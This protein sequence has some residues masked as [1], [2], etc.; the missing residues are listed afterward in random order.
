MR[1]SQ[2]VVVL[3]TFLRSGFAI[4]PKSQ[5]NS[6][7]WYAARKG[8]ASTDTSQTLH[9]YVTKMEEKDA[10]REDVTVI[11]VRDG[12]ETKKSTE[13][14]EHSQETDG[15]V[16]G[17]KSKKSN[18]VGDPDDDSDDDN[19]DELTEWEDVGQEISQPLQV[20]VELVEQEVDDHE[21]SS[22]TSG[23]VGIR[24][25]RRKKNRRKKTAKS[26]IP[27][28]VN[29]WMPHIYMPPT[30]ASLAFFHENAR[31]IDAAGKSRLDRRTLYSGLLL[32]FTSATTPRR[33]Y[34]SKE[35]TQQLQ[36]AVSLATQPQWRSA[37]PQASGIMLYEPEDEKGGATLSMQE[38]IAM[39]LVSGGIQSHNNIYRNSPL[40]DRLTI[41]ALP[42]LR[43]CNY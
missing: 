29:T 17:V 41:G 40:T 31:Q 4:H 7:R 9:D 3:L 10:S 38:T 18:A 13:S 19:D 26:T 43:V 35:T 15:D 42:R 24:L 2:A 11:E 8:V 1:I 36:A 12:D 32:E 21:P 37:F 34:F 27:L 16:V 23:G 30:A 25:G 33:K 6:P 20:E 28:V 22:S 14:P 5:N 39:A